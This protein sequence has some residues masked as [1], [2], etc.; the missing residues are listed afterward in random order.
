MKKDRGL[1]VVFRI[2][3]GEASSVGAEK[4]IA[5]MLKLNFGDLVR[6]V[7]SADDEEVAFYIQCPVM[8]SGEIMQ[9]F[10]KSVQRMFVVFDKYKPRFAQM[11]EGL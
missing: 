5:D 8:K 3:Q 7:R 6:P 4:R 10:F 11:P 9:T 1:C 2:P